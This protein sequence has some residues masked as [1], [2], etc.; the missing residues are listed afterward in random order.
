MKLNVWAFG[1]AC[2]LIWGLGL[3]VLTWW[4]IAFDGQTG[5]ATTF[6]R[7]YRGYSISALGSVIG[8]VWAFVDGLIGGVI[9]AWL[10]NLLA[11]RM[12]AKS[13]AA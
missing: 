5:E 6:G 3:F 9:F 11:G 13:A 12:G 1:L 4:I 7:I 8:L 10:Y 2:A